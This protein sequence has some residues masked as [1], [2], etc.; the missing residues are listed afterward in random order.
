MRRSER[1]VRWRREPCRA[2]AVPR[3]ASGPR[4]RGS[5]SGRARVRGLRAGCA[6]HETKCAGIAVRGGQRGAAGGTPWVGAG[7]GPSPVGWSFAGFRREGEQRSPAA[8]SPQGFS[9][10]RTRRY[11]EEKNPR[12]TTR[13]ASL[14]RPQQKDPRNST[15]G[16]QS[17]RLDGIGRLGACGVGGGPTDRGGGAS[18]PVC[19]AGR[20]AWQRLAV[21]QTVRRRLDERL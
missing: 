11:V 10:S 14:C 15:L 7:W 12:A 3:G 13:R 20:S 18:R 6:V 9:R 17:R 2:L 19:R 1:A 21:G 16:K 4:A 8:R 5:R